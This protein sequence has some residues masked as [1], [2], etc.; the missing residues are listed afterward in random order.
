MLFDCS[1]HKQSKV[2]K[3]SKAKWFVDCNKQCLVNLKLELQMK[4]IS[5][6]K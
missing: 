3:A 4:S 5:V 1:S 2:N 6:R